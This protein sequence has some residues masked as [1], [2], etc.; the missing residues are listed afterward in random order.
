MEGSIEVHQGD[1]E[2]N[3]AHRASSGALNTIK[4]EEEDN[5]FYASD[6]IVSQ[7]LKTF[8]KTATQTETH[9]AY[10]IMNSKQN[11]YN[12]FFNEKNQRNVNVTKDHKTKI[13]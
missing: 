1:D 12:F 11:T 13:T 5:I 6:G 9:T 2:R 4:S 8:L 7:Q 3:A 10:F